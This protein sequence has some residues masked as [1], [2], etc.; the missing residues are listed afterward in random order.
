[1]GL[2]LSHSSGEIKEREIEI[3]INK[4]EVIR[5][6]LNSYKDK[7]SKDLIKKVIQ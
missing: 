2:L 7:T 6:N 4:E 3:M 1:M 5:V